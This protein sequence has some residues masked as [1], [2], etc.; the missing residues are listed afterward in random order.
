MKQILSIVAIIVVLV[1][2]GFITKGLVNKSTTNTPDTQET[3]TTTT[4]A[5]A[6]ATTET[7]KEDS[8]LTTK[9]VKKMYTQAT[10]KTNVG[11]IVIT[12]DSTNTPKTTENFIKLAESGFYNGT[13]FHR[14][15]KGFMIQG[16]DPLSKDDS[17]QDYWGTGGPGYQFD[18]EIKSTNN[19]IAGTIS[20]A[21]AGPNTNG[22][23]FFIN[24][25]DNGFLNG[26]HTVFGKVSAG[27]DLVE[28]MSNV[29]TA[30]NDRPLEAIVINSVEL[31]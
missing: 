14:I 12:L 1:V 3:A 29:A 22:S 20:M 31:K 19:N 25:A 4:A 10:L 6:T 8:L 24:V 18:D 28:K 15:I 26:K 2:L 7:S 16:G 9:P 11:D 30:P 17:K 27:Y 21:N 23:Q 13:K 5:T